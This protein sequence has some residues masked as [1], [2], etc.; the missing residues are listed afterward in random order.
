MQLLVKF[1]VSTQAMRA[2]MKNIGVLADG[3]Y[4][5]QDISIIIIIIISEF[6]ILKLREETNQTHVFIR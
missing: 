4:H 6:I 3:T 1:K 5:Y 2:I